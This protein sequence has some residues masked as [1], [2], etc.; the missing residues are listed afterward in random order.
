MPHQAAGKARVVES[1]ADRSQ[2]LN[3]NERQAR[4]LVDLIITERALYK[5][6]GVSSR[7][8]PAAA[9]RKAYI[10]R[11]RSCHP[12]WALSLRRACTTHAEHSMLLVNCQSKSSCAVRQSAQRKYADQTILLLRKPFSGC[13]SPTRRYL[14][15]S[16]GVTTI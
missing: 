6:L 1:N 16:L 13:H 4:A 10:E 11:C 14:N 3:A 12:E 15:H 9:I 8:A 2:N 5:V 7:R